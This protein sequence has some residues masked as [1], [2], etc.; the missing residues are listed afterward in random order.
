M[1]VAFIICMTSQVRVSVMS[2]ELLAGP[3]FCFLLLHF[4]SLGSYDLDLN[5]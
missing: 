1:V 4:I 5:I 2:R 3:C